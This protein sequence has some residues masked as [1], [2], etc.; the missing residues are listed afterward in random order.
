MKNKLL[1]PLI[2]K[3]EVAICILL[4]IIIEPLSLPSILENITSIISY[5]FLFII[6]VMRGKKLFYTATI[7]ISFILL[8]FIVC[9]SFFWSENPSESIYQSRLLLRST[10]FAVYFAMQYPPEEQI[11]LLSWATGIIMI[12]SYGNSILFPSSGT[13]FINGS[14]AWSGIYTHKQILGRQMGIAALSFIFHILNKKLNKLIIATGLFFSVAIILLSQSKSGLLI[15]LFSI[16]IMPIYKFIVKQKNNRLLF[17]LILFLF[18]SIISC[19]VFFNIEYILVDFWGKDL[20][21][22][23]RLPLWQLCFDKISEQPWLGYGYRGFWNS[24]AGNYVLSN[25]WAALL[26]EFQEG[27]INFHAHNGFIDILLEIGSLGLLTF[28]I[29]FCQSLK[30]IIDLLIYSRDREFFWMLQI[31]C[32]LW[33]TNLTESNILFSS[34]SLIW[35]LYVSTVLSAAVQYKRLKNIQKYS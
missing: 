12:L 2:N 23:G 14:I 6:I 18:V 32:L 15:I 31:C 3:L 10:L 29:H 35:F 16:L 33:I 7:D 30:K 4:I 8:L 24:S 17:S 34:N 19:L 21:F 5:G 26:P 13:Q 25:S 28:F 1:L 20:E 22:N 11:K 27:N 9:F